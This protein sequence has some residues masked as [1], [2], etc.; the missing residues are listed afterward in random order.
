MRLRQQLAL[1]G[2]IPLDLTHL[3]QQILSPPA[4]LAVI[5]DLV[6]ERRLSRRQACGIEDRI[7]A[8]VTGEGV[9]RGE[10]GMAPLRMST[11]PRDIIPFAELEH[12]Q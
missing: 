6:Q 11:L 8:V 3:A 7:L 10:R 1:V 4:T 2:H 12:S 5:E 9:W